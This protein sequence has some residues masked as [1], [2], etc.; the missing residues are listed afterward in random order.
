MSAPQTYRQRYIVFEV[1]DEIKPSSEAMK[2]IV[3]KWKRDLTLSPS[4]WLIQ[5]D[6]KEGYG[7]LRCGH[8]QIGRLRE[9][10]KSDQGVQIQILGVSGTIKKARSKFL[11]A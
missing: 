9:R 4:P 10:I 5:Y 1:R 11:L 6:R 2:G 8:L 3:V 7:I